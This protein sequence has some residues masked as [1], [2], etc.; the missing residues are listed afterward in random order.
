MPADDQPLY[1]GARLA[2]A[3]DANYLQ[4]LN[5]AE[6][7]PA[8]PLPRPTTLTKWVTQAHAQHC[9][10]TL[11]VPQRALLS[12]QGIARLD[13]ED[14]QQGLKWLKAAIDI[15]K[16]LHLILRTPRELGPGP[17]DRERLVR[18]LDALRQHGA[19]S[20]I[21]LPSGMW[22]QAQAAQWAAR[23]QLHCGI[24]ALHDEVGEGELLYAVL[25]THGL[26]SRLGEGV[27]DR[28][29]NTLLSAPA[30]ERYLI[31]DS[32][33]PLRHAKRAQSVALSLSSNL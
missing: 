1:I 22:E 14:L 2:R 30:K 27:L 8:D 12:Q 23:Q 9:R 32:A 19:D 4:A 17:R 6:L 10:L 25:R 28:V 11:A 15:I 3:P 24:D 31:I 20:I 13:D 5:M 21:W 18:Y 29:C 26:Y 16:P 33:E 7:A